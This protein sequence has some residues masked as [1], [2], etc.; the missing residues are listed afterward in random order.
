[1]HNAFSAILELIAR[2][3]SP[4]QSRTQQPH[5]QQ[6]RLKTATSPPAQALARPKQASFAE[7]TRQAQALLFCG[8]Q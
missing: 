5:R 1:M 7:V 4:P 8:T 2:S 3:V 6:K